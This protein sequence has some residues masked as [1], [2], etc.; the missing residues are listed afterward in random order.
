MRSAHA[1]SAPALWL[2]SEHERQTLCA[3][4]NRIVPKDDYPS[5]TEA[6]CDE[7]I[8]RLLVLYPEWNDVYRAGLTLLDAASPHGFAQLGP[9]EQDEA[10]LKLE[11]HPFVQTLI[12]HGLEG[13]YSD[14]GNGGNLDGMAWQMVGFEVTA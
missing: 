8:R 13:F 3:A 12:Q 9:E 10:L 2:L 1:E 14:P 5:A 11:G 6:G 4:L 7:F